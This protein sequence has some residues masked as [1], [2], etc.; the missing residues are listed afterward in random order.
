MIIGFVNHIDM[1]K[2]NN[3]CKKLEWCT[4]SENTQKYF[5]LVLIKIHS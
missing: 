5:D 4:S 2:L 3:S 1:N